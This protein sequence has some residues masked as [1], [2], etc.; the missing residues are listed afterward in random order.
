MAVENLSRLR[1]LAPPLLLVHVLHVVLFLA[2]RP[3]S[4][5]EGADATRAG[6]W[7][8]AIAGAHGAAAAVSALGALTAWRVGNAAS[9]L[10]RALPFAAAAFYLLFGAL[11]TGIDQLVTN[12]INAYLTVCLAVALVTRAPARHTVVA[13]ALAYGA[14]LV[15]C[16]A[17]QAD[18]AQN[19]SVSVNGLTATAIGLGLALYANRMTRRRTHQRLL[20]EQQRSALTQA[21]ARLETEIA[22]RRRAEEELTHLATH[23][24]LTGLPN[25]RAF[26]VALEAAVREA[27]EGKHSTVALLDLDHFKSVNDGHGHAQG[28]EVLRDTARAIQAALRTDDVAA[29]LGGEEFGVILRGTTQDDAAALLEGLRVRVARQRW[30]PE[31]LRVTTSVGHTEVRSDDNLDARAALRR[32]D[33]ALYRAKADGRDRVAG[34]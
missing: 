33:A 14:L 18:A 8:L 2:F 23:D 12:S 29:R 1:T 17:A 20:I 28:D 16:R 25:R 31:D 21:N 19:L 27:R 13:Y 10:G 9:A 11:L 3:D 22:E 15:A 24:A 30:A 4:W 34:G 32:A 7:R 5:L 26:G 6:T